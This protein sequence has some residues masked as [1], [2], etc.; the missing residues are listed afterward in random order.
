MNQ[1]N[2]SALSKETQA[3]IRKE[4][5]AQEQPSIEQLY[6][7][8]VMINSYGDISIFASGYSLSIN[9]DEYERIK[10]LPKGK[11]VDVSNM[12]LGN[13]TV[14][15][16]QKFPYDLVFEQEEIDLSDKLVRINVAADDFNHPDLLDESSIRSGKA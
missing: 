6:A 10:Q 16:E 13:W 7:E 12:Q 4:L 9:S 5:L 2:L 8:S 14:M 15:E 1:I 3:K 11:R